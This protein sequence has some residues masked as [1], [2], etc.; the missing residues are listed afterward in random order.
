[1]RAHCNSNLIIFCLLLLSSLSLYSSFFFSHRCHFFFPLLSLVS[2]FFSFLHSPASATENHGGSG[3]V[4]V[5]I[6]LFIFG[7]GGLG[8]LFGFFFFFLEVAYDS[9]GGC[10]GWWCW[11][12]LMGFV[13]GCWW[14]WLLWWW[15]LMVVVL[16]FLQWVVAAM[17]VLV[18]VL[19]CGFLVVQFGFDGFCLPWV[20]GLWV[21][22]AALSSTSLSSSHV[23]ASLSQV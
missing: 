6:Y 10:F 23:E 14:R 12:I 8:G 1:M 20:L 21:L 4:E 13:V 15:W 5:F 19:V 7:G 9:D 16:G 18:V 3:G 2:L 11:F 17:V 22:F